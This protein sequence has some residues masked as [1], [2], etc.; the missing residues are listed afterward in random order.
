[1]SDED[2]NEEDDEVTLIITCPGTYCRFEFAILLCSSYVYLHITFQAYLGKFSPLTFFI[3][4][5]A[6]FPESARWHRHKYFFL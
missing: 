3:I 4:R 6:H 5:Q 1:M 2:E